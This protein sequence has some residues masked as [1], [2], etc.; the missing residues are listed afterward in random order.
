MSMIIG[1]LTLPFFLWSWLLGKNEEDGELALS[2][3]SWIII[4][5][6]VLGVFSWATG[7]RFWP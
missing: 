7:I 4:I 5:A 6:V 3:L 1:I 2:L